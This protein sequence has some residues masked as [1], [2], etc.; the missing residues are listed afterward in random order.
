MNCVQFAQAIDIGLT[1]KSEYCRKHSEVMSQLASEWE[2]QFLSSTVFAL[3]NSLKLRVITWPEKT[4][5]TLH[6]IKNEIERSEM[7]CDRTNNEKKEET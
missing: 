6:L 2:W 3:Q 5:A 1:K 7:Y 4:R